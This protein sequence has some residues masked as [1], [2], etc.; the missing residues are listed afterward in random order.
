MTNA[1]ATTPPSRRGHG[2]R[3]T[4]KDAVRGAGRSRLA[5]SLGL[6]C[7]V[8]AAAGVLL[9][10]TD[11]ATRLFPPAAVEHRTADAGPARPAPRVVEPPMSRPKSAAA[12][13][14]MHASA[15]PAVRHRMPPPV[16]TAWIPAH[17]LDRPAFGAAA[18]FDASA[19][20]GRVAELAQTDRFVPEA[21]AP[22]T[23]VAAAGPAAPAAP[24]PG[25]QVAAAVPVL[26]SPETA[27]EALEAAL[28]P[29][30]SARPHRDAAPAVATLRTRAMPP[31]ALAYARP[32]AGSDEAEKPVF[33][34]LF[35]RQ[36]RAGNGVAVYDIGAATVYLPNG[37]R[38]EAHSGLGAMRDN[39]RF[40]HAKNRGPTPP[41]TY[42]L[43]LR[44]S[45][46]HGVAAIRLTPVGGERRI[47][48][49]VGLLAHTY[50]LGPRGDSNGCVSFKDYKRFLAAFRRGEVRRL[51]VVP[52]MNDTSSRVA[53]LFGRRS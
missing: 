35:T 11:L 38:L 22:E 50:M 23:A 5:A 28:V 31:V 16:L 52:H 6:G 29:T 25:V 48:N 10:T 20:G 13:P 8:L 44:E 9:A 3:R 19:D 4:G 17:L 24:I 21:A 47:Y 45:L 33:G 41:H 39:P 42:D 15:A 7:G 14:A 12:R 36:P 34:G 1:G 18:G 2:S 26:P 37:E 43:R 53:S 40:V 49:R 32:D 46:F 27:E 51:V 30:P